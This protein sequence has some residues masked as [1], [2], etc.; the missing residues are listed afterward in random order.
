[1]L[2]P[3][4][5][6]T[7]VITPVLHPILSE[8]QNEKEIIYEKYF[9]IVKLLALLGVFVGI[10][11]FFSAKEIIYI[12]FGSQWGEAV[13]AFKILSISIAFQIALSSTGAI[14]QAANKTKELFLAGALGA[15]SN[16]TG[17]VIG[18]CLGKIEYVAIGV[19]IAYIIN[20]I[21]GFYLL[22]Y[23]VFNKSLINFIWQLKSCFIIMLLLIA[24]NIIFPIYNDNII[25][26]LLCKLAL[27]IVTYIIGLIATRELSFFKI[28]IRI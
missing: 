13:P 28:L 22:M 21:T 11:C 26:A 9:K 20:F 27:C 6:L 23:K 15:T 14:F 5:N 19:A 12:M 2:Y 24:S 8:Y 7:N 3:V 10:F 16:I 25:I 1:M 17:I 18:L 4:Q